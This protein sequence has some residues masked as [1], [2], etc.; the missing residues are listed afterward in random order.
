M[1]RNRLKSD[2]GEL[3]LNVPVLR[4]GRGLQAIRN[5]E[6]CDE[7]DWRAKHLRS[8]REKYAHAPFL[9]D[10]FPALEAVYNRGHRLLADLNMDLILFLQKA[11]SVEGQVLLQ[12]GLGVSGGGTDLLVALA[13][14]IG[15]GEYLAFSQVEKYLEVETF[16]RSAIRLRHL[17]FSAPVYPQLWG[18]HIYNLSALDMLFNCGPKCLEI[19]RRSSRIG[20]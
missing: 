17:K 19:L 2:A 10:Y 15:A 18:P 3:W 14:K 5:V 4:K 20:M 16:A 8:L 6:I 1:A 13:A 12:S 11:M 9:N 7:T